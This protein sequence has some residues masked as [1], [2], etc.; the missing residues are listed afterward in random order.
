MA[1][2][3]KQSFTWASFSRQPVS[4]KINDFVQRLNKSGKLIQQRPRLL[5]VF[6]IKPF[7]EPAVD[8][9]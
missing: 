9:G 2:A 1:S 6:R 8:L 7:G 5:Q 4:L 3:A